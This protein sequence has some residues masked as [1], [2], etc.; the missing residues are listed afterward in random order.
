MQRFFGYA[1]QLATPATLIA[2]PT[3]TVYDAG[4]L[5]PAT[6]YDD[7]LAPPTPKGNPFVGDVNGFFAF[8]APNGR[9]DV[10]LSGG[11]PAIP[12]PYTWGDVSLGLGDAGLPGYTQATL[13]TSGSSAQ[14]G[15]LARLTDYIRS[16]WMDMG[17]QWFS[18][19]GTRANVK[20]FGA[21]G[22]D[23][24]DDTSAIEAAIASGARIV[25]F[26]YGTYRITRALLPAAAQMWRGEGDV[27]S[28]IKQ[29]TANTDAVR[30]V[31]FGGVSLR[32]LNCKG[33]SGTG[34]GIVLQSAI[35]NV[36][37]S[38]FYNVRATSSGQDGIRMEGINKA[39]FYN[40]ECTGNG[41]DGF[42][43]QS[44]GAGFGSCD[45]N[46]FYGCFAGGNGGHGFNLGPTIGG[47]EVQSNLFDG[48]ASESNTGNGFNVLA[49]INVFQM[50]NSEGNAIG[51]NIDTTANAGTFI[52]CRGAASGTY[53]FEIRAQALIIS[54]TADSN[55]TTDY[56]VAANVSQATII[57]PQG[58]IVD[59][60][61]VAVV[62]GSGAVS[63][64][65]GPAL[66]RQWGAAVQTQITERLINTQGV[67]GVPTTIYSLG[68]NGDFILVIGRE[69]AAGARFL[70]LVLASNQVNPSAIQ[71][72]TAQGAPAAR[73]YTRSGSNL[74]LVMGADTYDVTV[75]AI[76]MPNPD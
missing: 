7:D 60:S 3:I 20:E 65:Y 19:F 73:T 5:N 2:T 44:G 75:R 10:R 36:S 32:D 15:R 57:Q 55:G 74:Q 40:V 63:Q 24:T 61:G 39:R 23:L 64:N 59:D 42:R 16:V 62:L 66:T 58:T 72:F 6:I 22:D 34:S 52:L 30:I 14:R 45:N 29:M 1:R 9:Y 49:G 38:Y 46:Y 54:G 26:P 17:T 68:G 51:F 31:D 37:N 25:F 35:S 28:V 12:T 71:S 21:V 13:P 69:Q 76:Q 18:L 27:T 4:T 43:C 47:S 48:C 67:A 41:R 53:G 50:C 33:G 56:H 70:D 8:Y 11:I